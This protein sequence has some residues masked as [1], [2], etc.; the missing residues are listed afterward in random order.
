MSEHLF[1][2]FLF[3]WVKSDNFLLQ[4]NKV[5]IDTIHEK[6]ILETDYTF[7][8]QKM[9]VNQIFKKQTQ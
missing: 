4:R 6:L 9:D 5:N 3:N 2:N 7:N 8:F 1:E